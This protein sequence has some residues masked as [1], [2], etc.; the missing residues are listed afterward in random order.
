MIAIQRRWMLF[1]MEI[2]QSSTAGVCYNVLVFKNRAYI[3]ILALQIKKKKK[4]LRQQRAVKKKS[5]KKLL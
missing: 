1:S 5:S 2:K 4:K 3:D